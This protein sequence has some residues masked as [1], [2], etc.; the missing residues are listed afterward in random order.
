VRYIHHLVSDDGRE[1]RGGVTCAAELLNEPLARSIKREKEFIH[2]TERKL[3]DGCHCKICAEKAR[4]ILAWVIAAG[5]ILRM[6]KTQRWAQEARQLQEAAAEKARIAEEQARLAR[7]EAQ[8][9]WEADRPR[10]EA[11]ARRQAEIDRIAREEADRQW[12]LDRPRREAEERRQA[13]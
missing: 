7:E 2:R 5:G 8:R 10:R 6:R 13:N 3:G 4:F 9:Q 1:F 11:E 12:D